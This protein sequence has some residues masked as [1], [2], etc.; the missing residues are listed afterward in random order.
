MV[1]AGAIAHWVERRAGGEGRL[2]VIRSLSASLIVTEA[3]FNYNPS[4]VWFLFTF[5]FFFFLYHFPSWLGSHHQVL[6]TFLYTSSSNLCPALY[7]DCQTFSFFDA[8]VCILSIYR[9][10]V[11]RVKDHFPSLIRQENSRTSLEHSERENNKKQQRIESNKNKYSGARR[12]SWISRREKVCSSSSNF[13]KKKKKRNGGT[14]RVDRPIDK[15]TLANKREKAEQWLV[16]S[17]G[18]GWY[19]SC[20]IWASSNV[21]ISIYRDP[22]GVI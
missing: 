21:Y 22:H 19:S 13:G 1:M 10:C 14:T 16:R 7:R 20:W 17:A 18:H 3:P 5:V 11:C 4:I 9:E 12:S 2:E 15:H 8:C 6:L